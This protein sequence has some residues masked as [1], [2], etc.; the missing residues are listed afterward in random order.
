MIPQ[1]VAISILLLFVTNIL[2]GG[3]DA[4]LWLD[5]NFSAA[6]AVQRD[7]GGLLDWCLNELSG[8]VYYSLLWTW[9]K[10]GGDSNVMLRLPSIA[11]SILSP[12]LL[13][14]KGHEDRELRRLW[15]LTFA[16]WAAGYTYGTEARPY[17]LM[18][19]FGSC[20]AI[21]FLRLMQ[22]PDTRRATV[23]IAISSLAVLTHYHA[24]VISALQGLIY[25][26]WWRREALRSWPAL[27]VLIV[28]IAW[29]AV[30]LRTVLTFA[31]SGNSW[32]E[33]WPLAAIWEAP[34]LVFGATVV[35]KLLAL[36]VVSSV[37]LWLV[38]R[39]DRRS[40]LMC[41]APELLL[42]GSGLASFA[43]VFATAFIVPS[44]TPRY[45]LPYIPAVLF[46]VA[47]WL[48]EMGSVAPR[49][50]VLLIALMAGYPI[51][52]LIIRLEK[53]ELDYRFSFNFEQPSEWIAENG[54]GRKLIFLWDN[55]TAA[56]SEV[57]KLQEVGGFFMR[58]MGRPVDVVIPRF[59]LNTDPNRLILKLAGN[60]PKTAI[61]WAYDINVPNS[62][63]KRYPPQITESMGWTCHNFGGGTVTVLGCIRKERVRPYTSA[64]TTKS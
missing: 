41:S 34:T 52:Q 6:I 46:G 54:S 47:L 64:A 39:R 27:F 2:V 21:C 31:T 38:W 40:P 61:I 28:P 56:I 18:L 45:I 8:P 44:F 59:P 25:V 5:E 3:L 35:A 36:M 12:V 29:M 1:P 16:L 43:I 55:P 60:D 62:S 10:V 32:Y 23:W 24:I 48:R 26:A 42:A 20:Q 14:W 22:G 11:I 9:E 7:I 58:R 15:A 49:L 33:V 37:L 53:P 30:H 57:R 4:P 63:G 19:F 13:F 50:P 17:A 51:N